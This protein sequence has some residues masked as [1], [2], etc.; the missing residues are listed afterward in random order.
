MKN[1]VRICGSG[2]VVQQ[3]FELPGGG[4]DLCHLVQVL[5]ALGGDLEVVLLLSGLEGLHLA[6]ELS[7]LLFKLL[8]VNV[9]GGPEVPELALVSLRE[10]GDLGSGGPELSH[11]P[12]VGGTT[13]RIPLLEVGDLCSGGLELG[14]EVLLV[15]LVHDRK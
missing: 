4:L 7:F 6:L 9:L 5:L 3:S 10:V 13:V 2:L 14:L 11:R 1:T 15:G 12:G 8:Q